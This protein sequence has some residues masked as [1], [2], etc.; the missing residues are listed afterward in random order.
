MKDPIADTHSW[1]RQLGMPQSQTP[2]HTS[3][4]SGVK[5]G[6]SPLPTLS[7]RLETDKWRLFERLHIGHGF[8]TMAMPSKNKLHET[9]AWTSS[10]NAKQI[11]AHLI[12][13]TENLLLLLRPLL[14]NP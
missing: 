8:D 1:V 5:V 14:R 6:V 9:N 10:N 3:A 4:N 11:Q 7:Y 12:Y 2:T 13:L